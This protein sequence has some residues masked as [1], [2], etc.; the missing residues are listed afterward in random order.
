[1]VYDTKDWAKERQVKPLGAAIGI[2]FSA[3][4]LSVIGVVEDQGKYR[5]RRVT[6]AAG[7][8]SAESLPL[9]QAFYCVAVAVDGSLV[10][11][12]HEGGKV[13]L[14]D[15][16][17]LDV[18]SRLQTGKRGLAHPFFSP[19]AKLLAAGCQETGD[20]VIWSVASQQE[21]ARHTFEKGALRTYYNRQAGVNVRPER[22]PT[23]FCFSPDG[24]AFLAGCYGGI[25]RATTTGQELA[26]FGE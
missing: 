18:K 21:V 17:T 20:V 24:D 15:A 14:R 19:D 13:V 4:G 8:I 3:D 22:D 12:G 26:R 2:A 1:V 16:E 9:E 25:L 6:L 5:L 7:D 11:T 10:A 23:R